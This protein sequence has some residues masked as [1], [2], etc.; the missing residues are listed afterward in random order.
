MQGRQLPPTGKG[1]IANGQAGYYKEGTQSRWV[2][3]HVVCLL[4]F[5]ITSELSRTDDQRPLCLDPGHVS[6]SSF[7]LELAYCTLAI[8]KVIIQRRHDAC[9]VDHGCYYHNR[10]EDLVRGPEYVEHTGPELFRKPGLPL[11]V[12]TCS[13]GWLVAGQLTP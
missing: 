3:G 6:S 9:K 1:V 8:A 10:V 13:K 7:R 12:N 4:F 11:G 5:F 2:G